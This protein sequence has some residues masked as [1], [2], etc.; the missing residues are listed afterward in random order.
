MF[1]L[2]ILSPV[3]N[4]FSSL[5]EHSH[6]LSQVSFNFMD[7]IPHFLSTHHFVFI[8]VLYLPFFFSRSCTPFITATDLVPSFPISHLIRGPFQQRSLAGRRSIC[9]GKVSGRPPFIAAASRAS[10][11]GGL[12]GPGVKLI[13]LWFHHLLLCLWNSLSRRKWPNAASIKYNRLDAHVSQPMKWGRKRH[14]SPVNFRSVAD[15]VLAWTGAS[16]NGIRTNVSFL[17]VLLSQF[18]L[19]QL[20][21]IELGTLKGLR[22]VYW[23][24]EDVTV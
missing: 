23:P 16:G 21:N 7:F 10:S 24:H 14:W 19:R 22:V 15:L 1:N 8:L 5:H 9:S 3:L 18:Y 11:P 17:C 20:F 4:H 2:H 12:R 13:D 6:A